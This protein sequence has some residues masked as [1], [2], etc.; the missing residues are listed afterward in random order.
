MAKRT[1]LKFWAPWCNPCKQLSKSFSVVQ[2]DVD[3]REVNVDEEPE[4]ASDYRVRGIPTLVLL[5]NGTEI[6]RYT[7]PLTPDEL[8]DFLSQ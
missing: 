6:S 3:L 2:T 7:G 1:V 5:E 4:V 8:I